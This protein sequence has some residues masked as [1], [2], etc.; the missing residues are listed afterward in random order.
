MKFISLETLPR[1]ARAVQLDDGQ[2]VRV[3]LQR[4]TSTWYDYR[5][6]C[7]FMHLV[8]CL[9]DTNGEPCCTPT[10]DG[11]E[12]DHDDGLPHHT[13]GRGLTVPFKALAAYGPE[14][15]ETQI[16]EAVERAVTELEGFRAAMAAVREMEDS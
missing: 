1:S 2:H 3:D 6:G 10:P 15:L 13:P 5:E 14:W 9:C 12:C 4:R 8:A 11:M 16:T 7:L